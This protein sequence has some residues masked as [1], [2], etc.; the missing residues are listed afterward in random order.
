MRESLGFSYI[1]EIGKNFAFLCKRYLKFVVLPWFI[2]IFFQFK[3][4]LFLLLFEVYC[5]ERIEGSVLR[6]DIE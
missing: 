1:T 3:D 2:D 6:R 5:V 4:D